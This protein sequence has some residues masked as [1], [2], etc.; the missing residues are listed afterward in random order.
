MAYSYETCLALLAQV[1]CAVGPLRA[2]VVGSS[3]VGEMRKEMLRPF[4]N[5]ASDLND[6]EWFANY[7]GLYPPYN[8]VDFVSTDL[9]SPVEDYS[10]LS[11]LRGLQPH[12]V[13]L[14]LGNGEFH[15]QRYAGS[16]IARQLFAHIEQ[17]R[18]IPSV[19]YVALLG[20]IF[21]EPEK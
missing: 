1:R 6:A 3:T 19:Q 8:V 9:I 15:D 18:D 17:I 14:M 10:Y 5:R 2:A 16:T 21:W 12:Y 11:S 4:N 13:V 20:A 7:M